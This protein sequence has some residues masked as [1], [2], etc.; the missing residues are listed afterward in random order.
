MKVA[1]VLQDEQTQLMPVP[2]RFDGYVELLARVTSTSLIHLERN[3][4]SV[5]TEHANSV[6]SL[7]IYHDH[8]AAVAD[9][10]RVAAHQRCFDRSQT[11]YDWQHYISLLERKPGGLRNGAP[12]ETMPAAFKQL[13]AILMRK[14]GG[15]AVMAQVLAAVPVHGLDAVLVA[16]ELA[17]E[18][19]KPSGE[20]VL[21]V[22]ARLKSNTPAANLSEAMA[23]ELVHLP[24]K[25]RVEP[26]AN[27]ARYDG[28]R[29]AIA[30]SAVSGV[31]P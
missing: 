7:R 22:L 28:L 13:Q 11:F 24:L 27:V 30:P 4:Y 17:L 6:V 9:G 26:T 20:H 15:D 8:I 16:A 3:R 23:A 12:F 2:R 18:S 14:S 10:V 5:P 29:Q 25:L 31:Q 19:S 1:D 21:N